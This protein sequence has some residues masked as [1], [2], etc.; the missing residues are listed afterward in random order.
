MIIVDPEREGCTIWR[1]DYV[2]HI[3]GNVQEC[4]KE[5]YDRTVLVEDG[6]VDEQVIDIAVDIGGI[7]LPYIDHLR[8][9]GLRVKEIKPKKIDVFLPK[10]NRRKYTQKRNIK[11]DKINVS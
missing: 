7:G 2:T 11:A 1:G 5:I 8:Y 4:C 10:L 3:N 6:F 9:M